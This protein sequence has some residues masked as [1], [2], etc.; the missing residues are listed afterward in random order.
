MARYSIRFHLLTLQKDTSKFE[1]SLVAQRSH[2]LEFKY[3]CS[4]ENSLL[5][6]NRLLRCTR[7]DTFFTIQILE[8]LL[9]TT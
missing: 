2:L 6:F 4:L 8:N 5:M 9:F 1:M 3:C 7:N